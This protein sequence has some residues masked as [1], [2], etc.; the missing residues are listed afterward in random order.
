[1]ISMIAANILIGP[2]AHLT[3]WA[4]SHVVRYAVAEVG[5]FQVLYK[6]IADW[7]GGHGVDV[8][9]LWSDHFNVVRLLDDVQRI[10]T[11]VHDM[12]SFSLVMVVYVILGYSRSSRRLDV[13]ST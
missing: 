10:T 4:C 11:I 3:T 6:Q 12:L 5:Q 7:L 1:M 9:G 13:W 8:S 2:F